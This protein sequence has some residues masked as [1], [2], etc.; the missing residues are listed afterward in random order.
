MPPDDG[1]AHVDEE[2]RAGRRARRVVLGA[3]IGLWGAAAALGLAQGAVVPLLL[4]FSCAGGLS[5][6]GAV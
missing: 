3:G 5:V 1:T 4:S 6:S 2:A